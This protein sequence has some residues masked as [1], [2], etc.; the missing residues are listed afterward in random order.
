[1]RVVEVASFEG[2]GRGVMGLLR[3]WKIVEKEKASEWWVEKE[4]GSTAD[5]LERRASRHAA[6][7]FRGK[8]GPEGVS[9]CFDGW[10]DIEVGRPSHGKAIQKQACTS[11]AETGC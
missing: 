5:S 10:I 7:V 1:M 11:A 3:L 2:V 8:G 4:S 6:M 9:C